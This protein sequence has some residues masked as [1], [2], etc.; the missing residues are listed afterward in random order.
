MTPPPGRGRGTGWER[1]PFG[2]RREQGVCRWMTP[3]TGEIPAPSGAAAAT[4]CQ[5]ACSR[6]VV[7]GVQSG[8]SP[9]YAV[10]RFLLRCL[11]QGRSRQMLC[12]VNSGLCP[13]HVPLQPARAML[14]R[15]SC[16]RYPG[17]W[18]SWCGC[19][20]GGYLWWLGGY[21]HA[22]SC[23]SPN[24]LLPSS[25]QVRL[26]R[27]CRTLR[28]TFLSYF[29]ANAFVVPDHQLGR[30]HPAP[31]LPP[32]APFECPAATPQRKFW[33]S[34]VFATCANIG[35]P[36][37]LVATMAVLPEST[38]HALWVLNA[39]QS[40]RRHKYIKFSERR[41][42]EEMGSEASSDGKDGSGMA[43]EE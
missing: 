42:V 7:V 12:G 40:C 9:M 5:H 43:G 3:L 39:H 35:S 8:P 27:T 28:R 21:G 24:P 33:L 4:T 13:L 30:L 22:V 19:R 20:A 36:K 41:H 34:F 10:R 25:R 16:L 31:C 29:F 18:E 15:A 2:A 6:L 17:L 1:N 11:H 38:A 32:L 14:G 37:K 26:C 23:T